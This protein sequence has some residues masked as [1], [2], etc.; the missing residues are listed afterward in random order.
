[1]RR[2]SA[3]AL[4]RAASF[5]G[6]FLCVA[7]ASQAQSFTASAAADVPHSIPAAP[8]P[9]RAPQP[10]IVKPARF[11][12]IGVKRAEDCGPALDAL[13]TELQT[14]D[15]PA[16]WQFK[17]ACSPLLWEMVQRKSDHPDAPYAVSELKSRVTFFHAALFRESRYV[18]RRTMSH[19]LGH[20]HCGCK[21]EDEAEK[22]ARKLEAQSIAKR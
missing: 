21:S 12:F 22:W 10:S 3:F 15:Y 7:V 19:E 13:Q 8:M 4:A 14:L 18:Y 2:L 5:H 17:I 20:I 6:L 16:D 9:A 11:T 1:M